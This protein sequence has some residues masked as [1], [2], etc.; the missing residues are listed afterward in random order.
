MKGTVQCDKVNM[1]VTDVFSPL[2]AACLGSTAPSRRT[3]SVE[4]DTL[5]YIPALSAAAERLAGG[6]RKNPLYL[7]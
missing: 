3:A 1:P 4:Y 2:P 5:S 7:R 6:R